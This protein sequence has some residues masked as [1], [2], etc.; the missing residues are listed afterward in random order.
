M[1]YGHSRF[2]GINLRAARYRFLPRWTTGGRANTTPAINSRPIAAI[3][4]YGST[5]TATKLRAGIRTRWAQ[6]RP[7]PSVRLRDAGRATTD[8]PPCQQGRY[9]PHATATSRRDRHATDGC[10]RA[11]TFRAAKHGDS[12]KGAR[13]GGTVEKWK[14][15]CSKRANACQTSGAASGGAQVHSRRFSRSSWR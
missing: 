12:F 15:T 8:P 2:V 5:P 13:A 11:A 7:V 10:A 3:G 6:A 1:P 14:C 4:S 9:W